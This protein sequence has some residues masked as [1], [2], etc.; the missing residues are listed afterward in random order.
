MGAPTLHW[1]LIDQAVL[2]LG[3][4]AGVVQPTAEQC[5]CPVV[6]R[7]APGG[8]AAVALLCSE[9]CQGKL[10]WK[11]ENRA[12]CKCHINSP[13]GVLLLCKEKY[14]F[15]RPLSRSKRCLIYHC[16]AHASYASSAFHIA[17]ALRM[18][19][20]HKPCKA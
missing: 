12:V 10:L 9:H 7:E 11:E 19:L 13:W 17:I 6:Q 2:S 3:R 8:V 1:G 20:R 18:V 14:I 15:T 4:A 5:I 16:K